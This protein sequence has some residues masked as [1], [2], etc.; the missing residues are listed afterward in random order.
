[1][2]WLHTGGGA[3]WEL[4]E[5]PL[6]RY[7]RHGG[8]QFLAQS[9]AADTGILT[10][11]ELRLEVASKVVRSSGFFFSELGRWRGHPLVG[12]W[13]RGPFMQQRIHSR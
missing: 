13:L 5:A 7:L 6:V 2:G 10:R 3:A 11:S 4:T 1:V 8:L 9:D 12:L